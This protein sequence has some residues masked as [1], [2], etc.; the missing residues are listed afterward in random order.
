MNVANKNTTLRQLDEGYREFKGLAPAFEVVKL[1]TGKMP[2]PASNSFLTHWA[3]EFRH[4]HL[5]GPKLVSGIT[6]SRLLKF[7]FMSDNPH[8]WR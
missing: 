4:R 3:T 6:G 8:F 7:N 1:A 2:N 5:G